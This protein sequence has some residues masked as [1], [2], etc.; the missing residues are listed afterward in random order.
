MGLSKEPNIGDHFKDET[1][2]FVYEGDRWFRI[3]EDVNGYHRFSQTG[4]PQNWSFFDHE[5][6]ENFTKSNN[7]KTIYDILNDTE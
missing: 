4:P 3:T 6:I 5:F 1:H 2:T 7:F